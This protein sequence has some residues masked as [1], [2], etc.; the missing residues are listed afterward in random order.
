MGELGKQIS[1]NNYKRDK[2]SSP[3]DI[4]IALESPPF[5]NGEFSSLIFY[6]IND[7]KTTGW[8]SQVITWC[9]PIQ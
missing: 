3:R 7:K 9:C 8:H 1:S 2:L 5:L 6:Q 4:G